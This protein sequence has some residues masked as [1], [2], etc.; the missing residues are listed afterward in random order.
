[1]EAKH[2][3]SVTS[4]RSCIMNTETT[5]CTSTIERPAPFFFTIIT[6]GGHT[7]PDYPERTYAYNIIA[8]YEDA[9]GV[10][11]TE[12]LDGWCP[13]DD[14]YE[15]DDEAWQA[16]QAILPRIADELLDD[17]IARGIALATREYIAH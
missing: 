8:E 1:M 4:K 9:D 6:S 17:L 7:D 3:A 11:H 15:T 5:N 14:F 13:D 16:A 10:V 12:Y 2:E